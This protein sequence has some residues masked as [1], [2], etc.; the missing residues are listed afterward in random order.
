MPMSEQIGNNIYL[1]AFLIG[2]LPGAWFTWMVLK[3]IILTLRR[4]RDEDL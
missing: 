3:G 4:S 1:I 2:I